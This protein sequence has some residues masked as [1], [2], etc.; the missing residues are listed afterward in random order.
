MKLTKTKLKQIIKEEL[1]TTL[2]GP[3]TETTL[4]GP[5]TAALERSYNTNLDPEEAAA[6]IL[7]V[8]EAFLSGK[9]GTGIELRY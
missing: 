5:L 2:N 1:E 3:L 9:L 6:A 7:S 4:N 8:V